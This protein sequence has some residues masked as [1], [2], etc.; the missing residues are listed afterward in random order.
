MPGPPS[1]ED[2][3]AA[4]GGDH[5]TCEGQEARHGCSTGP[6]QGRLRGADD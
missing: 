4:E 3:R 6:T 1:G 5:M 2:E